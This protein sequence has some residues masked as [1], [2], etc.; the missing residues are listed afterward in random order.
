MPDPVDG[1][2]SVI[3][4]VHER[5]ALLREAAASALA[6]TWTRVEVIIVDDGSRDS[7]PGVARDLAARHRERVRVIVQSNAGPAAARQA[8]LDAARGEFVQ[9][10]D[11]DD[12]LLPDKLALQV[13]GLREHPDCGVSYGMTRRYRLGEPP[14]PVAIKRTG[15]RIATLFPSMLQSRWWSTSTPL[16][17]RRVC[18]A[19]GPWDATL[20]NEED[21][22]YDC[23]V[24]ALGTRLHHVP[25]FV[26]ETRDHDAGQIHTAMPLRDKL[27]SRARAHALI[28]GHARRAG[29]GPDT[30][31]MRH[32]ARELFLLCRQ[33][34]A[35]RLP[36]EARELFDLAV[37]ASTPKRR[38]GW[39]FRLYRLAAGAAGWQAA[40]RL[41]A[42]LDRLRPVP[43]PAPHDTAREP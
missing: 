29:I 36:G 2:V 21:W 12:L 37:D 41:A 18:D 6:Q 9:Y 34:G 10:L 14:R 38:R 33:C 43:G 39:D 40:G 8:G 1:L 5:P 13:A 35:A 4:P 24:A 30:A 20:R 7:T 15:E 25:A 19:A 27:R 31:E 16:Y 26:S 17:R 3:I 11:S 32:F 23:R 28:L 22:E 42:L